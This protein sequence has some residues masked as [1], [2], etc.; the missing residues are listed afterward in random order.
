MDK[1]YGLYRKKCY[2]KWTKMF[3]LY[4]KITINVFSV[5]FGIAVHL[6]FR[7]MLVDGQGGQVIIILMF[8][9]V[10]FSQSVP[11]FIRRNTENQLTFSLGIFWD[12]CTIPG[13]PVIKI[14]CVVLLLVCHFKCYSLYH[15]LGLFS[16]RQIDD[17]FPRKQN[18]AFHAN[19]LYW[20]QFAWNVK[21]CFLGKYEQYLNMSSAE[22][23]TQ[24][25]KH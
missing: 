14:Y 18:L 7:G 25:A 16:R 1:M 2:Q 8:K 19:C 3:R 5:C 12:K 9:N 10:R 6:A 11:Q 4:R 21:I 22:N 20:R 24:R 15:S 17:I 23:F 13:S